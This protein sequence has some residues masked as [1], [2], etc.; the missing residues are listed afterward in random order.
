MKTGIHPDPPDDRDLLLRRFVKPTEIPDKVDLRIYLQGV[1]NQ[2]AEGVCAGMASSAMKE[3]QESRDAG[4]DE[5]LSPRYV[6]SEAKKLD[7]M[8]G[9]EGTTNRAIM[10]ALLTKG[11]CLDAT[12]PYI[13]Y[14]G[15]DKPKTADDEAFGFR[16]SSYAKMTTILDMEKCLVDN[17][18]FCLGLHINQGWIGHKQD[19]IPDPPRKYVSL[20]GHD[21]LCCGYDR[22]TKSFLI[23]NSWGLGW[24]S[25]GYSWIS[26]NHVMRC[27]I[28]AWSSIDMPGSKL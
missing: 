16:I 13:S 12:W 14:A 24:G 6:Y 15:Y 20:G 18:P 10:A 17:G 11:I 23:R 4:L 27:L 25:G 5:Y 22:I 3:Y 21:V 7:G 1:R 2:G 19:L 9:Q 8:P 28:S 26:Y